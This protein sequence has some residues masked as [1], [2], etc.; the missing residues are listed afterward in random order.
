VIQRAHLTAW[1]KHAPWDKRSKIEQDLRA[2]ELRLRAILAPVLGTPS[3]SIIADGWLAVRNATKPSKLL[4]TVFSYVPLGL[5]YPMTVKVEVN[6]NEN[7]SLFPLVE[8]EVDLLNGD[9]ELTR[10]R[11]R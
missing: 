6:L 8:V 11:A 10:C 2:L 9:G 7:K 5:R 3:D 4:R 1:Q